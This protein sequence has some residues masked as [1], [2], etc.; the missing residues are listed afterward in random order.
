MRDVH[1]GVFTPQ[2]VD[3]AL[4]RQLHRRLFDGVRDHAGKHRD[5]GFGAEYLSYGPN[6]SKHRDM[7]KGE[8]ATIFARL[9][10]DLRRLN[11]NRDAPNFDV[12]ALRVAVQVHADVIAVHPFEDGNGRTNRLLLNVVLTRLGLP[13]VAFEIPKQEYNEC[14]NVYFRQRRIQPLVDLALRILSDP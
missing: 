1:S 4:L 5:R 6:R 10:V 7:V 3:T 13:P 9:N 12:E 14:L 11:E 2:P 8:L